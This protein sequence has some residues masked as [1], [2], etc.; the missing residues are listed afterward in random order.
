MAAGCGNQVELGIRGWGKNK[1]QQWE[2]GKDGGRKWKLG[3]NWEKI[4][5][6]YENYGLGEGLKGNNGD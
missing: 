6:C 4:V 2:M 1:Y 5:G 3:W